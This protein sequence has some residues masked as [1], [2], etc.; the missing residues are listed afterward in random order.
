METLRKNQ[1]EML[2]IKHTITKMKNASGG[3]TNKLGMTKERISE[4]D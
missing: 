1:K 2:T 4:L 3:L